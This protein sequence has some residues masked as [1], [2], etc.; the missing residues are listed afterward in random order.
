M[1]AIVLVILFSCK[2]NSGKSFRPSPPDTSRAF[3]VYLPKGV[4]GEIASA[5]AWRVRKD[6]FAF[7]DLDTL[8]KKKRWTRNTD[9]YVIIVDT[10]RNR[11]TG[12][13]VLD[14]TGNKQVGPVQ[15]YYPPQFILFDTNKNIDSMLLLYG[16]KDTTKKQ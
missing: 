14:S 7:V 10:L 16:P 1:G 12:Q 15:V 6:T 8:T 2:S 11:Q 9:Y 4:G 5:W 13:Y 3:I